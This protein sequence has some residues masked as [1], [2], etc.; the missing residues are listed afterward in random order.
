MKRLLPFLFLAMVAADLHAA[1]GIG[2][3]ADAFNRAFPVGYGGN[4]VFSPCSFE[5][6]CAIIAESLDTIPR[7]AV[8][9]TMGVLTGLQSTYRPIIDFYACT[10][11]GYSVISARGFCIPDFKDSRPDFRRQLQREYAVEVMPLRPKAGAESWFRVA[12]DGRM[13]EFELP[14]ESISGLRQS[15]FDLVSVRMRFAEPFPASGVVRRDFN[16]AKGSKTSLEFLTDVRVADVWENDRC[17]VLSLPL[18]GGLTFLAMLP[19]PEVE[20]SAVREDIS[21]VEIVEILSSMRSVTAKGRTRDAVRVALPRLALVSRV[22]LFPVLRYFRV[23]TTGL[24]KVA[25]NMSAGTY[26]QRVK[27]ELG[28]VEKRDEAAAATPVRSLTFDR[29]FVFM[30]YHDETQTIP[31]VGQYTGGEK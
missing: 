8:S 6:D 3:E 5:L 21:S 1:R 25:G 23:P 30:V 16:G 31:V 12:M 10:T 26:E 2:F 15:F 4:A 22:N 11:N 24:T 28:G 29:P 14:A 20:L 17:S 27:F 7:A 9:E 18:A 13:E 19:K